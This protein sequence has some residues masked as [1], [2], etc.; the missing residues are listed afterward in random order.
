LCQGTN[1]AKNSLNDAAKERHDE[2][3]ELNECEQD[4]SSEKLLSK[5]E[6]EGAGTEN[7]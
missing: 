7:L 4:Q 6:K 3:M 2:S 5:N 1:D